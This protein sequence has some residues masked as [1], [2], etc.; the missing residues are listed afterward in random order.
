MK[1]KETTKRIR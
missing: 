1:D